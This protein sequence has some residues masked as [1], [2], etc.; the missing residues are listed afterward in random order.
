MLPL[1]LVLLPGVL[2]WRAGRMIVR[3]QRITEPRPAFAGI[4][5]VAVPYGLIAGLLAVASRSSLS[6]ASVPEA[7]AAGFAVAFVAAG[8]GAAR[9]L[10]P[11]RR[12]A[13]FATLPVRSVVAGMTAALAVLAGA[14]AVAAAIAL[15]GHL[16]E[17]GAVYRLLGPNLIGGTL[18]LLAQVAY[19]PNAVIWATSYML[20]PGFAIGTGTVVAPS[21]SVLGPQPAFPLLAAVP[22]GAHGG[23]PAWLTVVLMAV[24]YLAGGIGGL[25]CVRVA[26]SAVLEAAFARGFA[27]GAGAGLVLGALA[28]FSGGPL[29]DGR[30]SAVGPSAWQ[31]GLVGVLEIGIAGAIVAGLAN[32]W[33]LRRVSAATAGPAGQRSAPGGDDDGHVIYMDRWATAE[34]PG[35]ATRRRRGPSDLP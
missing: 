28:A 18:L 7:L 22:A 33:Q 30:M 29:G 12:L 24:P 26:R 34:E 31:V 20:G 14:G 2:L 32:W 21:G 5:A 6:A 13:D 9:A 35:T 16:P 10:A 1:G 23:G 25:I 17:Y 19:L 8:F 15:A 4:L 11:W 27:C 3:G